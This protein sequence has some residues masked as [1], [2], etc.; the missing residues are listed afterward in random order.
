MRKLSVIQ[1]EIDMMDD[2]IKTERKKENGGDQS[3]IA[4]WQAEKVKYEKEYDEAKTY[5]DAQGREQAQTEKVESITLPYDY[6]DILDNPLANETIIEVVKSFQRQAYDEH[7][8]EVARINAEWNEKVKAINTA[9]DEYS[10]L[11]K[12]EFADLQQRLD[13]ENEQAQKD[14]KELNELTQQVSQLTLEKQDLESKH[15]AAATALDEANQEIERLKQPKQPSLDISTTDKLADLAARAKES[16]IEKANR[17][18]ARWNLPALELPNL[19]QVDQVT[20]PE[21]PATQEVH[22]FQENSDPNAEGDTSTTGNE[23]M[24]QVVG[25]ATEET[26]LTLESLHERLKIVEDRLSTTVNTT[27]NAVAQAVA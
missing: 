7:N 15:K 12:Q 22:T 26:P 13:A 10:A 16:T 5:W 11:L 21:I 24:E 19:P 17:G 27:I 1:S 3:S 2:A 9:A 23:S 18:L 8:T 14:A 4:T 6:N 25:K 20:T